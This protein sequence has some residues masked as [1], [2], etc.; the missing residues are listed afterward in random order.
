MAL[1]ARWILPSPDN[2]LVE[3][4][5][6][7]LG[8]PALVARILVHRGHTTAEAASAFLNPRLDD[9]HPPH[10]LTGM[11]DA[12]ARIRRAIGAHERILLYGDYDVDGTTSIVILMKALALAGADAHYFVPHR[13]RDGYGMREEV[14]EQASR[15]KVGLIVSVDTGIRAASVVERARELGIDVI[16]TDHHLPEEALPPALAVLNPNRPDCDYPEKNLCGAGVAFKLVQALMDSLAWEPARVRALTESFLK[17]V[18]IATVA[19]VVPLTGEN[20][21]IVHHGLNG[22]TRV[23]N[24]GLRALLQV[25]G[26][27]EGD[28]PSAGQ[29]AFRIAPRINAAGRMADA[30]QVIELFLTNDATHALTIA[31]QLH[32]WNAERQQT[33]AD[34]LEACLEA[35]VHPDERALVFAGE[36]WHKGVVGIVASRLVERYHRPVFVLTIDPATGEASG[37]GRS[38]EAFHLLDALESMRELFTK[39]GGHSHAAGVTLPADRIPEFRAR[40]DAHARTVLH[41]D[42]LRPRLKIDAAASFQELTDATVAALLKLGPFGQGNAAPV[43]MTSHASFPFPPTVMKEKH[44]RFKAAHAGKQLTMKAWRFAERLPEFTLDR[45]FDLAYVVEDDPFSAARG[46]A[47]WSATLRDLR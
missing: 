15:D 31:Q 6:R 12:V 28:E 32:E 36:G 1:S 21:I 43:L 9:L 38:I 45:V 41:E 14:I 47:P 8:I 18:A 25:A 24:A 39:F 34:T 7:Q 2:A 22:L 29:V 11:G 42:D 3:T 23:R 19:D 35:Q 10:L 13:I 17:M 30:G 27:Q 46:Y 40:F 26:F 5:A 37:S 20:R 4:L 33:E 16:V 44:L